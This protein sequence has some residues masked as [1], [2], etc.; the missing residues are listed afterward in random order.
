[1]AV[2]A[3]DVSRLGDPPVAVETGEELNA[4]HDATIATGHTSDSTGSLMTIHTVVGYFDPK[5]GILKFARDSALE[6]PP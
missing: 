5:W 6:W 4:C 3:F 1:M 2:A